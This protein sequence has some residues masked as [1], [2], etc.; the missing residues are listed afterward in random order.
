MKARITYDDFAVYFS[1]GRD[2]KINR[3]HWLLFKVFGNKEEAERAGEHLKKR[4]G[5]EIKIEKKEI[6]GILR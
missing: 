5:W 6:I 2:K 1:N 3:P 4:Y